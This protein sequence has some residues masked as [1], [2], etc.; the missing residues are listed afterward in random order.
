MLGGAGCMRGGD[1]AVARRLTVGSG[2]LSLGCGSLG[3]CEL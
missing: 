2:L 1:M 3:G